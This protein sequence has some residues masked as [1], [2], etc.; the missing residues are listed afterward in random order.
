MVII[1]YDDFM[2]S[3]MMHIYVI[4]LIASFVCV[5]VSMKILVFV[6]SSVVSEL[7]LLLDTFNSVSFV[8][9]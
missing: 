4:E 3:V 9:F 1:L 7:V 5:C 6:W 2:F 8:Y